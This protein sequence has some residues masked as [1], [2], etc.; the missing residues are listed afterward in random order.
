MNSS[1]YSFPRTISFRIIDKKRV[2]LEAGR[3][4]ERNNER[5]FKQARKQARKS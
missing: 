1:I 3:K 2:L 4:N 5:T